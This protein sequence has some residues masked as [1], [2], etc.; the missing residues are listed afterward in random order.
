MPSN[1]TEIINELP[2]R[3]VE[4]K[5]APSF[6]AIEGPKGQM[7]LVHNKLRIA[8]SREDRASITHARARCERANER[9]SHPAMARFILAAAVRMKRKEK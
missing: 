9:D 3:S 4:D 2:Q 1:V 7:M 5:R 8:P 6:R